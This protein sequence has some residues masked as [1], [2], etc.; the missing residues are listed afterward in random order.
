M[1]KRNEYFL[2]DTP[3]SQFHF[4]SKKEIEVLAEEFRI[5]RLHDLLYFAPRKYIDRSEIKPI[6]E[7]QWGEKKP[8]VVSGKLYRIEEVSS[9]KKNSNRL[10][11][12]L[13]DQTGVLKLVWFQKYQWL[14]SK[15]KQGESYL[16]FGV[17]DRFG[18]VVTMS[19]PEL[20]SIQDDEMIE[21]FLGIYPVYPSSSK[22]Q[23]RGLTN[24]MMQA[25]M[26]KVLNFFS[27]QTQVQ[28]FFPEYIRKDYQIPEWR[29]ALNTLHF[30]EDKIQLQHAIER[31]KLEEIFLLQLLLSQRK[32]LLKR[33]YR[34]YPFTKVG[35]YFLNFYHK[36][37]PFQLTEDQKRV[38]KEI[39]QDVKRSEP[40]NRLLQGDVG[41]GKTIV[42][43]FTMLLALD[44][45]CQVAFMAPTEILAEQHFRNLLNYGAPLNLRIE[46]LTGSVRGKTREKILADLRSGAIQ[47]L[48]GT[49]ALIE[50]SVSFIRLGLTII[51]EQ[52]KFG[53]V[54]R[55]KLTLR[56][57]K[58]KP[59][60]LFL[61]ATPIPRS[62]SLVFYG[63]L[64][65]ST[66]RQLP[67]GRKPIITRHCPER[68]RAQL[69]NWVETMLEKGAQ[70]Y[71]VYPVIEES[72]VLDVTPVTQGY[73]LLRKRFP[74]VPIGMIHGRMSNDA[75]ELEMRRFKAGE[76]KILVATT[77]I[78]VGVDV[79]Q[80]S[81]M[82]VE[83]AERFGLSQLHQLRGRVGRGAQQSYCFLVTKDKLTP[84]ARE[85]INI[86]VKTN[87][88]F[89]IAQKDLDLRGPGDIMGTKQSGL[90]D[91]QFLHFFLDQA[92]LQKSKKIVDSILKKDVELSLPEHQPLKKFLEYYVRRYNLENLVP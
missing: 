5:H 60:N 82:I 24:R 66:I 90:P 75:K 71:V 56:G 47:I 33:R 40:M 74:H 45:G 58:V 29:Q 70:V 89:E 19:H 21:S 59:H 28:D 81:I 7:I 91:F 35:D 52:H 69:W 61:S 62:L 18:G 15:L 42:A 92:I 20:V 65:I 10:E 43:F 53:V 63:D 50:D 39:R 78:E 86:L 12:V 16:V 46:L 2:L 83:N 25:K 49:H 77:V 8:V 48:V 72:E 27:H 73:E 64:D 30:P 1:N 36:Y 37:L 14:K 88:G 80:A 23:K 67:P 41:S 9:S 87:N 11:A 32:Y 17:P 54:Q 22:M 38:I 6:R 4:F 34:A 55:A 84:Q 13:A 31:F 51:D 26:E 76:T 85:R 3:I 68:K 44:N 79:P 57:D